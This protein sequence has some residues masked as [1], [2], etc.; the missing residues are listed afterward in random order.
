MKNKIQKLILITLTMT[1]AFT[2]I[3][4]G[5]FMGYEVE[6][7]NPDRFEGED[8]YSVEPLVRKYNGEKITIE[9]S[10]RGVFNFGD[11]K[12]N[13]GSAE[14]ITDSI[15]SFVGT[16]YDHEYPI[17]LASIS[18]GYEKTIPLNVDINAYYYSIKNVANGA[19]K[20]ILPLADLYRYQGWYDDTT[21]II[22]YGY[23]TEYASDKLLLHVTDIQNVNIELHPINEMPRPLIENFPDLSP[24]G[25]LELNL[26]LTKSWTGTLKIK[27]VQNSNY[28]FRVQKTLILSDG[29]N[30]FEQTA[31]Q[32]SDIKPAECHTE[33]KM[34]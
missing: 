13:D 3:G 10:I 8:D 9:D 15:L 34:D 20:Y 27:I 21:A 23:L 6:I 29:I 2:Q 33:Y 22:Q 4:C 24:Q 1:G 30:T 25:D 18:E 19:K 26:E 31:D 12:L 28:V 5:P 7:C 17:K 11:I 16:D 14:L 32:T